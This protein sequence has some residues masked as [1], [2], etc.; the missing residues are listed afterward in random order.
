[1]D[2]VARGPDVRGP[3]TV[4][5][6]ALVLL[7]GFGIWSERRT[8]AVRTANVERALA[9][10]G[11]REIQAR[12]ARAGCGRARGLYVWESATATGTACAGPRDSVE[13]RETKPRVTP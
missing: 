12:P 6:I 11:H 8:R 9:E 4:G 2:A 7:G 1:M 13:I 10:L 5:L 3:L